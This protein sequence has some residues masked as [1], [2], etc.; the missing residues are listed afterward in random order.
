M[1]PHTVLPLARKFYGEMLNSVYTICAAHDKTYNKTC[2]TSKGLDQPVHLSSRSVFAD[3]MC[4]LQ[5][6][7]YP[8]ITL[9]ILGGCA[10]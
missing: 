8:K 4:L 5:P 7:G 9:A 10:G 1:K 2:A 6:P 3:P